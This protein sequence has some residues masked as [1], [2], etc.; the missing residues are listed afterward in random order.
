MTAD[1]GD[2]LLKKT[3]IVDLEKHESCINELL[4]GIGST[5]DDS[6]ITC[7][8]R[9]MFLF[10]SQIFKSGLFCLRLLVQTF[11]SSFTALSENWFSEFCMKR[12]GSLSAR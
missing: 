4:A 12:F 2:A 9:L 7:A 10:Y 5:D 8:T 11:I 1:N 6:A 3:D